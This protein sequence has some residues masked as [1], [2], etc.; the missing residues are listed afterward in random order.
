[1]TD[2]APASYR[3]PLWSRL[4]EVDR[5]A[6]VA[7]ALDAGVCGVGG[8]LA[9]QPADLADLDDVVDRVAAA[10][11]PR[12]AARLRRFAEVEDGVWVW[13]QDADGLFHRGVLRGPWRYDASPAAH[14]HDLAHVRPCTW[15]PGPVEPPGNV[16]ATF[17]RG[18]RNFQRIN[19]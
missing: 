2:A 16:L 14:E 12:V 8:R 11:D 5:W 3:A 19:T 18:G 1:M 9:E 13:T 17:A 10:W 7:W 15:S 4:D 6:A